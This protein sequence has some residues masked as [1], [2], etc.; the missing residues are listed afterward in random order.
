MCVDSPMVRHVFDC[1]R[2]VVVNCCQFDHCYSIYSLFGKC[3]VNIIASKCLF[4]LQQSFGIAHEIAVKIKLCCG[5]MLLSKSTFDFQ[6]WPNQCKTM[7]MQWTTKM[8]LFRFVLKSGLPNAR[9]R[10]FVDWMSF[11]RSFLHSYLM[12]HSD[13]AEFA[14]VDLYGFFLFC[15]VRLS[16]WAS[17]LTIC[18]CTRVFAPVDLCGFFLFCFIRLSP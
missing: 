1:L 13:F 2:N 16:C 11:L 15:F 17:V 5:R 14:R 12:R 18:S 4:T 10:S 7:V 6:N 9:L 3:C 8:F